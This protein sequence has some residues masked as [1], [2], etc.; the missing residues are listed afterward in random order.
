MISLQ[1]FLAYPG[2]HYYYY[3][4]NY[5]SL[6]RLRHYGFVQICFDLLMY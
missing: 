1:A 3:Y 2:L 4:N 6:M 5:S